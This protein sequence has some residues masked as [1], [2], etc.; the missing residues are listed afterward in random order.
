MLKSAQKAAE[1]KKTTS[2]GGADRYSLKNNRHTRGV[3][4]KR[5][6]YYNEFHTNAMQWAY[7]ASTK[8][9]DTKILSVNGKSFALLESTEDG[10]IEIARG[11]YKE[12]LGQYEEMQRRADN[13]F[14]GYAQK[15]RSDKSGNLR[16]EL[17]NKRV[18]GH[19]AEDSRQAGRERLQTDGTGNNEHLRSGDKGRQG[20]QEVDFS[21]RDADAQN[22]TK[23][24]YSLAKSRD[25]QLIAKA[26]EYESQNWS[27]ESIFE[28]TG[29]VRDPKGIWLYELDDRK[30]KF[31]P[32]G[33]VRKRNDPD[34]EE[35]LKY[36][37]I[38]NSYPEIDIDENGRMVLT[39]EQKKVFDRY[40]ELIDILEDRY[41][42]GDT[43]K[44]YVV[45]DELFEKYP[46]IADAEFRIHDHGNSGRLG[47]YDPENN[48]IRIDQRLYT[49]IYSCM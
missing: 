8:T 9:G 16:T 29:L 49:Q 39:E 30:M 3:D 46:Q 2:E 24:A 45:H 5:K 37:N 13:S 7:S 44:D 38:V 4:S 28:E 23:R 48:I 10:Y 11:N 47:S 25:S 33:D 32:K 40:C 34:Y 14:Y 41:G 43:L 35:F 21:S 1:N 36:E 12:V 19:V 31:Y 6:N 17:S 26:E 22:K 27:R 42:I 15:I 20:Q 18:G